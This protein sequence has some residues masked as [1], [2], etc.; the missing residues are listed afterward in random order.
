MVGQ[1][2]AV[3]IFAQHT[4]INSTIHYRGPVHRLSVFAEVPES[5]C[6]CNTSQAKRPI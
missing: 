4:K 1:F 2:A 5:D 3:F 6:E